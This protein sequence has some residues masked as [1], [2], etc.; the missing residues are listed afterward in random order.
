MS[1]LAAAF[2]GW[3]I[4]VLLIA[5]SLGLIGKAADN[6]NSVKIVVVTIALSILLPL[7]IVLSPI[8]YIFVKEHKEVHGS[9][10]GY[11]KHVFRE[12]F[13]LYE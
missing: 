8:A 5:L 4:A 2:A 1:G 6:S 7:M 3:N 13:R 10:T 9:Y 11:L 12:A